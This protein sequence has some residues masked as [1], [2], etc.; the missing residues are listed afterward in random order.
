[1]TPSP[2]QIYQAVRNTTQRPRNHAPLIHAAGRNS[3]TNAV[4]H[5]R[6]T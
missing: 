6:E 1:M 4:R 5:G 3:Q 2:E